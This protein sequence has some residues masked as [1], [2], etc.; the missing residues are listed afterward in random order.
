MLIACVTCS[1][2]MLRS[3]RRLRAPLLLW[4]SIA[5]ALIGLKNAAQTLD[6]VLAP[7]LDLT[8]VRLLL[9]IL[10]VGGLAYGLSRKPSL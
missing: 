3:W 1:A 5:L 8:I 7:E 4:T 2:L 9:A 10:A 6:T